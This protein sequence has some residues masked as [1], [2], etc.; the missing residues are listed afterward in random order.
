MNIDLLKR[1]KSYKEL[2]ISIFILPIW[3]SVPYVYK[4]LVAFGWIQSNSE[5][6]SVID[7]RYWYIFFA[8][9]AIIIV[10]Y[11]LCRLITIYFRKIKQ[12]SLS[13][14]TPC[15][16]AILLSC[17][18]DVLSYRDKL[19]KKF[20]ERI[21]LNGLKNI[22]ICKCVK[23]NDVL[24]KYTTR[25]DASKYK[26]EFQETLVVIA[27]LE[28]G[29]RRGEMFYSMP[30]IHLAFETPIIP[31]MRI[32]D[33]LKFQI[34]D[35]E[36]LSDIR[37]VGQN[38]YFLSNIFLALTLFCS[39]KFELADKL[40]ADLYSQIR[41]LKANKDYI[42]IYAFTIDLLARTKNAIFSK[43]YEEIIKPNITK[44]AEEITRI[45]N[46]QIRII[47]LYSADL[48][49][50]D[51][52]NLKSI[53]LFHLGEIKESRNLL[54]YTK[55]TFDKNEKVQCYCN[56]S[57][58]FLEMWRGMYKLAVRRYKAFKN[59][60]FEM[61]RSIIDFNEMVIKNNP[62][63]TD[64]QFIIASMRK[65]EFSQDELADWNRFISL[66]Q[67]TENNKCLFGYA[68]E[69]IALLKKI[70]LNNTNDT[71]DIFNGIE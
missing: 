59:I 17:D 15:R 55:K 41:N 48:I 62:E 40:V 2:I 71:G 36:S 61:A 39:H 16:I 27:R 49:S 6:I 51:G 14:G 1:V 20:E 65:F 43:E 33:S 38:L 34:Q 32:F 45:V 21:Y 12:I 54:K 60:S 47:N 52:L 19:Y 18:D 37:I 56:L 22:I 46:N 50:F 28:S 68:K 63:R 7:R 8:L 53:L 23:E 4:F 9:I 42:K 31:N 25:K 30:N 29:K 64:L 67:E 70:N 69:R 5:E 35:S 58:A 26:E 44:K 66:N 10:L 13:D 57:L 11:L 3:P 24:E